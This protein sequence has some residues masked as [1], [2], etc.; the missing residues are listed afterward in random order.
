MGVRVTGWR[1]AGQRGVKGNKQ[2]RW[3]T[4]S[5]QLAGRGV[6]TRE[7]HITPTSPRF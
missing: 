5:Q 2:K 7:T 3:P 1:G 4:K 6:L